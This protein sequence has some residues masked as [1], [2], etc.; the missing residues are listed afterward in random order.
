MINHSHYGIECF[1][2]YYSCTDFVVNIAWLRYIKPNHIYLLPTIT[3]WISRL[4]YIVMHI[5][6][7]TKWSSVPFSRIHID[8]LAQD[9][10]I[11]ISNALEILQSC[12]EPSIACAIVR[13][14]PEFK[15]GHPTPTPT[16][17]P[18]PPP[19]ITL[20]VRGRSMKNT[21]TEQNLCAACT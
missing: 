11:S 14:W 5:L 18:P 10:S 17:P 4:Q 16:Q 15:S 13:T 2:H 9:C 8:G 1:N 6:R 3:I 20:R 7:T 19:P 21:L 12:T